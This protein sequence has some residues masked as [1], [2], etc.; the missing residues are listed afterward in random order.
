MVSPIDAA[1]DTLQPQLEHQD[2]SAPDDYEAAG[3]VSESQGLAPPDENRKDHTA[4][5]H[6]PA[7]EH[8]DDEAT[9]HVGE[10]R[11]HEPAGAQELDMQPVARP[12]PD[13]DETAAGRQAQNDTKEREALGAADYRLTIHSVGT[14]AVQEAAAVAESPRAAVDE[15]PE[16]DTGTADDDSEAAADKALDVTAGEE[17]EPVTSAAQPPRPPD[18][19]G[20]PTVGPDDAE[21]PEEEDDRN[22]S[23][24]QAEGRAG[25][26]DLKSEVAA[27]RIRATLAKY[28]GQEVTAETSDR[29][30]RGE[31]EAAER[32]QPETEGPIDAP[33]HERQG[34]TRGAEGEASDR[35]AE[36][37]YTMDRVAQIFGISYGGV[38]DV[39][40]RSDSLLRVQNA[41]EA[42]GQRITNLPAPYIHALQAY[43]QQNGI[44]SFKKAADGFANSQEGQRFAY[45]LRAEYEDRIREHERAQRGYL[46]LSQAGELMNVGPGYLQRHGLV[47]DVPPPE[48]QT[49]RIETFVRAR[50]VSADTV[51]ETMEWS[52]TAFK[53][54]MEVPEGVY[55][56]SSEVEKTL[57]C[58]RR[59]IIQM[60]N[61]GYIP[62]WRFEAESGRSNRRYPQ[63]Y[64][65]ELGEYLRSHSKLDLI[66]AAEQFAHEH[67]DDHT[68]IRG[69]FEIGLHRLA[70]ENEGFIPRQP[71]A[72]YLHLPQG[73]FWRTFGTK[74]DTKGYPLDY[75]HDRIKWSGAEILDRERATVDARGRVRWQVET[76]G[77]RE[78]ILGEVAMGN[79]PTDV[80]RSHGIPPRTVLGWVEASRPHDV[81]PD[82]TA[83]SQ[84]ARQPEA[85]KE[86]LARAFE[87]R[88]EQQDVDISEAGK[89][90]GAEAARQIIVDS[91]PAAR[92][93]A[94]WVADNEESIMRVAAS[95][96]DI[97]QSQ[98]ATQIQVARLLAE[99]HR[100]YPA[101]M[102]VGAKVFEDLRP[103]AQ[104]V[105]LA[106]GENPEDRPS[107]SARQIA[108][109]RRATELAKKG[110]LA[111]FPDTG[112]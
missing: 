12:K 66:A 21:E 73:Q 83:E 22:E 16:K 89:G 101:D 44:R 103:F 107:L 13:A 47:S 3:L 82:V 23:G 110:R 100:F 93:F 61:H 59:A 63:E 72:D 106:P 94:R 88:R 29:I 34:D 65:E 102:L 52:H 2:V 97:D 108:A 9:R 85:S 15:Q 38:R 54:P 91:R 81:A 36:R 76:P 5:A 26:Q 8:T 98:I 58:S 30:R 24:D 112:V 28:Y 104:A 56:P 48:E 87:S 45:G 10:E 32:E 40:A 111:Y 99:Q 7:A 109:L 11:R 69:Q 14:R 60:T 70:R 80:A 37:V 92:Q 57:G 20:P 49:G 43:Q 77:I 50:G 67:P 95:Q 78:Q 41:P 33:A 46:T 25:A 84:R 53:N 71:L 4:L 90:M 17:G 1:P 68:L 96:E 18:D 86:Q 55:L 39:L 75:V 27:A 79:V 64:V 19:P 42:T 6:K 62:N 51:R 31:E 35:P 74:P 105:P